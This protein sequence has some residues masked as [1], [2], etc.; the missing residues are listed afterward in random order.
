[1]EHLLQYVWMHKIFPL[2]LLHTTS[3]IPLE[4]IDS[5]IRNSDAGPDFFNAKIKLGNTVWVGNIEVHTNSSDWYRHGHDKDKSYNSIILHVTGNADCE[6]FRV[7]GQTIPQF[8]LECPENVRSHYSELCRADYYPRC[9][10]IIPEL[11]LFTIHSWLTSLQVERLELKAS[12]I[13]RRVE[14]CNGLWEDAF[15][16]TLARNFGFGLNGDTFELWA[17]HL[18]LRAVDKHRDNLVQVE[19]L[20]F[21]TAG[22]LE[23]SSGDDYY[24]VLRT[25][26]RYL[27]KKFQLSQPI[28]GHLWRQFRLR[29]NNFCHVRIA[30]LAA[31][32]H[33]HPS[34]FSSFM[35]VYLPVDICK[36][37]DI[38]TS[39][40][41][42]THFSFTHDSPESNKILG[43]KA[44]QLIIINTLIPFLYA[45]GKH[46]SNDTLCERAF[47]FLSE[48]K[49][50][51]NVIIRQWRDSGITVES[52]ADS[53]ALIQ[54]RKEYC[55]K[56]KCLYCRF[57]YE[58]L[59]KK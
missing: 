42:N 47:T 17:N 43:A 50:E 52:A 35:D 49:S 12:A 55:E 4:I 31:L 6:L 26:Y 29:P 36:L 51:E 22:L 57:G 5:G 11:S 9:L 21:G 30:Q 13:K 33:N 7:D 34:L 14:R 37:L 2:K 53:Q 32:Y 18:P 58:F 44:I 16:V 54:L 10:S 8:Q 41:W 40:Y 59:K 27:K 38:K 39:D 45:Y 25:E 23:E 15:I 28:E 3:G 1:M 48:L 19:A 56:K 20:F 24:Q 46:K